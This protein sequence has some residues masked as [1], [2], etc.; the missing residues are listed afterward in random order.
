MTS[1]SKRCHRVGVHLYLNVRVMYWK[2][3]SDACWMP[4]A[5]TAHRKSGCIW[6][7]HKLLCE[8][9]YAHQ[10][11]HN[12]FYQSLDP[13]LRQRCERSEPANFVL[14]IRKSVWLLNHGQV[15]STWSRD[16][17]RDW[18]APKWRKREEILFKSEPKL[19]LL[20]PR[21]WPR[22]PWWS[23]LTN[24]PWENSTS[25]FQALVHDIL[26]P[27]TFHNM[28]ITGYAIGLR[29]SAT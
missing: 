13:Q 23:H 20:K 29:L 17:K 27:T 25:K 5:D 26:P 9:S 14:F 21:V 4:G 22:L 1:F 28:I 2:S 19:T 15:P 6:L 18:G 11:G 3:E 7:G 10:R 12:H 16:R 24:I 8:H